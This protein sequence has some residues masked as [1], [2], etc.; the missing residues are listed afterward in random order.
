MGPSRPSPSSKP[1]KSDGDAAQ[2]AGAALDAADADLRAGLYRQFDDAPG[3][4]LVFYAMQLD[5]AAVA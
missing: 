5:M 2:I 1:I 4:A 3:N